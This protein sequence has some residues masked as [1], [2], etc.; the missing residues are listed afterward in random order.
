MLHAVTSELASTA[1]PVKTERWRKT[2]RE[3][4]QKKSYEQMK[5]QTSTHTDRMKNKKEERR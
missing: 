5:R 4:G 1:H 2:G 3:N